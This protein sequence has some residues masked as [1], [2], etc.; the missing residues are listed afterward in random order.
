[1]TPFHFPPRGK[2]L[3]T[4]SPA[5]KVGKWVKRKKRLS[6]TK[7]MEKDQDKI[8]SDVTSGEYKY[9]FYSDI[10][11]D[12]IPKGLS[13]EVVRLISSKKNEPDWLLE[14]RLK[15]YRHWLTMKMPTWPNLKIAPI[16]Y[17]DIIFYA[18]PKERKNLTSIDDIDP[19]LKK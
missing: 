18:A 3:I 9:G 10:E 19:E 13:E 8:I 1:M 6:I 2:C 4:P 15:S 17:Q 5:G 7:K 11:M 14:F 12:R 16:N